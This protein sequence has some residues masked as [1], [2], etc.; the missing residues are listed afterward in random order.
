MKNY[1]FTRDHRAYL[2]GRLKY[3]ESKFKSV[4]VQNSDEINGLQ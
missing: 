2:L 4:K 3:K 1:L